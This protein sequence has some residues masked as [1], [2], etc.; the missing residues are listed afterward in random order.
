MIKLQVGV[1]PGNVI[2]VWGASEEC[3][4]I[5]GCSAALPFVCLW[6]LHAF[7]PTLI[8]ETNRTERSRFF[9]RAHT[10]NWDLSSHS[11]LTKRVCQW[12]LLDPK[13]STCTA[14]PTSASR[15]CHFAPP[16][17]VTRETRGRKSSPGGILRK[18]QRDLA[19]RTKWV[20]N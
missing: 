12:P 19:S 2:M 10:P 8:L 6:L 15:C 11:R 3:I 16:N 17:P 5:Q 20:L 18:T 9:W 13:T 4:R 14:P 7:P 1:L